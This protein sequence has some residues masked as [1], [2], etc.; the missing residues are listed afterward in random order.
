MASL[1]NAVVLLWVEACTGPVETMEACDVAARPRLQRCSGTMTLSR[2]QGRLQSMP[3]CLEQCRDLR[4][5]PLDVR[6][7]TRTVDYR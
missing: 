2:Y 6:C 7:N 1:R 5:A 3:A 4:S